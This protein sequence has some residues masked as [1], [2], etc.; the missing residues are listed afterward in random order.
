MQILEDGILTSSQGRKI[1]FKNTII[2]MT[3]NIGADFIVKNK[4][5]IGFAGIDTERNMEEQIKSELKKQFRPEFLNRI[6]E[7][8]IFNRLKRDDLKIICANLL[9][10]VRLRAKAI[11][12]EIVFSD[13]TKEFLL[14]KGYDE[15]YGARPMKR[16]I[17]AK[18]ENM[19]AAYLL[20]G[21]I[22]KGDSAVVDVGK[23]GELIAVLEEAKLLEC[24]E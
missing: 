20:S 2:I 8:I 15:A 5:S 4:P 22:K 23:D 9:E 11:G 19:L 18:V 7:V 3:S 16:A 17:N 14:N 21:K 6:D 12:I 10:K 24:S 13:K 1:N